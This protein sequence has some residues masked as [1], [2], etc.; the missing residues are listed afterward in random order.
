M[1]LAAA[2]KRSLML[3]FATLTCFM[4]L[5]AAQAAYA[6]V[7]PYA[8]YDPQSICTPKAKAGTQAL[9][10]WLV[11]GYGGGYGRIS[12]PCTGGSTSEHKEGRAFDWTLTPT[13]LPTGPGR[14]ATST[15]SSPRD[16]P[17]S[18]PNRPAGW[19]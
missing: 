17:A 14:R 1:M 19:A 15:G 8:S 10:H 3:L 16:R 5:G 13:K 18:R 7:E 12:E 9:G 4:V 11:R 6:P 2:I